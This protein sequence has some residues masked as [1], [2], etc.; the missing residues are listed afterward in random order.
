MLRQIG[1]FRQFFAGWKYNIIWGS[2]TT[3]LRLNWPRSAR[4]E[5]KV[6]KSSSESHSPKRC[7]RS[8][9]MPTRPQSDIR[10]CENWRSMNLNK[11][12]MVGIVSCFFLFWIFGPNFLMWIFSFFPPIFDFSSIQNQRCS[13]GRSCV[14]ESDLQRLGG[15]L[16]RIKLH[17]CWWFVR[18]P[19]STHQLRER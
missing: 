6:H 18:N 15:T 4:R 11:Q 17:Y 5:P 7:S 12:L 14:T 2:C 1:S 9:A 19:G 13:E 16:E 8:F 10:I 3:N